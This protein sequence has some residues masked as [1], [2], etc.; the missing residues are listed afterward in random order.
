MHRRHT[1]LLLA[2]AVLLPAGCGLAEREQA[3][4]SMTITATD[5]NGWDP[6]H[7]DDGLGG[8]LRA[9]PHQIDSTHSGWS[10]K[11]LRLPCQLSKIRSLR[12]CSKASGG[13]SWLHC[14]STESRPM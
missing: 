13:S 2:A 4:V 10:M 14:L 11:G 12:R 9:D 8:E 3:P 1:A 5:W 6:D 7:P